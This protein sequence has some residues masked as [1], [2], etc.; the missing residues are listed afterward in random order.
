[1]SQTE[2]HKRL[3][4]LL[5]KHNK[6]RKQQSKQ[7]DILCNDMIGAQREFIRRLDNVGFA[8]RFYKHLLG[9]TDL[10]TLLTRA[11]GLIAEE[12]P[13][14]NVAFFLRR[15]ERCQMH[16]SA[17]DH[18]IGADDLHVEDWFS[19][20]VVDAICK[21]N[22]P[23]TMDDLVGFGFAVHATTRHE[24]SMATVPLS[25]LGRSLGFVLVYRRGPL[26]I[27]AREL[28]RVGLITCG[29]SRAVQGCRMPLH[30]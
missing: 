8:A 20:E 19:P 4:L 23:C 14:T 7:I 6:Q 9:A 10:Y 15:P 26:P 18:A 21:Q 1:M 22:R 30:A 25:D 29:L 3:R 5:K 2:R 13:G 11:G 17:S 27:S 12:L 24:A 28:E 16:T